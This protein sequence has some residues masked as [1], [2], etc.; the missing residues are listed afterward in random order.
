MRRAPFAALLLAAAAAAAA[1]ETP[2]AEVQVRELRLDNGMKFLLVPRPEQATV[3]AGWV[4]KVGSANERPGITGVAHFFE[5]MMFKGSRVIGTRDAARDQAIIEEQ[6][7][8]QEE[9]RALYAVQRARYRKGE[10]ADPFDPAARPPELVALEER[11]A[12]LVEEQRAL[13]VKEEFDRIYT[14]AG[15][16][17][18]NATTNWDSTIYFVTVPANKLE[19]WFWM[20][21]ERLLQPVFREFYAERD[22]VQEE[23]RL[24]VE[25]TPTGPFDEQLNAMF[26]TSHPYKWDTIGWM[27]D[28]RTLSLADARDFFATFYAPNNLTA[29]LVGNFDPREVEA[30]A[31]R[32][33]GRLARGARPVPD[34]VTLEEPQ[35]AEKRM[36]AQCDC[37]PQVTLQFHTTPFQHADSFALDVVQGLLNGD[38]G[39]LKRRL[40]QERQLAAAASSAQQSWRLA[41]FF[42]LQAETQGQA[43]TAELEAGLWEELDRLKEEPVP[44]AE[45]EKVKNQIAADAFRNLDSPFFLM[46]QL[47][48]Y[49][50]WGDWTYLN[51]WSG[52]T[53]AVTAEEVQRVARRYFTVEN[54]TVASY[55]RKAGAAPEP[56]PDDLAGLPPELARQ[57][58]AQVR[59]IRQTEDRAALERMLAELRAQRASLPAEV[60]QLT[61]VLER[62][63]QQ[64]LDALGAAAGKEKP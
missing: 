24:R 25:S 32:Y 16:S 37:Q 18:M 26:W 52:R 30:L 64:R 63:A 55:Q 50:G 28:L 17:G 14:E 6:E 45:L 8:L 3:M 27:S 1:G 56:L 5:H 46:L 41:G 19:L 53:L 33:F 34:V 20:E 43:T 21:S 57:A 40:V 15:A 58:M 36:N 49:E 60:Q 10:I 7:R 51:T 54:R 4:A 11:F 2:R 29:A 9:I 13:M 12:G 31:H 38:S 42:E 44:A 61:A 39:R 23:R 59:Q 35:R 62:E 47:L 22:V 48:F